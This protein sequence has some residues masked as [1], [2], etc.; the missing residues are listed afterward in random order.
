MLCVV[1]NFA[2]FQRQVMVCVP[3]KSW[4][5]LNPSQPYLTPL[6]RVILLEFL[7]SVGITR[8]LRDGEV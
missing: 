7:Q 3:L 1:K 6:L 8:N 2:E 5:T 4:I